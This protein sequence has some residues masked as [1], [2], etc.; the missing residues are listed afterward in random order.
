MVASA[1]AIMRRFANGES[2]FQQQIEAVRGDGDCLLSP[3]L[4]GAMEII[5]VGDGNIY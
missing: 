4:P 3:A 5:D 2:F 1:A